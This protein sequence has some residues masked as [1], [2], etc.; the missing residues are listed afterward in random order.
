MNYQNQQSSKIKIKEIQTEKLINIHELSDLIGFKSTF[1]NKA[2]VQF[3]LPYYKIGGAV[4]F[5]MSEINNW[6][7]Q[8]KIIN[9]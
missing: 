9:N 1:I 8:R 6:I 5:K 4:R 3:C 2:M 7:E